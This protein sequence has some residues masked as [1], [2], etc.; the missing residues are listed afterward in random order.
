M[1]LM[2]IHLT[3]ARDPE[4]PEGSEAH[5]YDFVAPLD[6]SGHLDADE[7]RKT[8]DKCRVRRFWN[9]DADE[10]GHLIHTRGRAWVFHYDI[11][12]PLDEDEPGYRFDSHLF[13][14]GEYVSIR[15]QD[16]STR[17]FRVASVRP[18]AVAAKE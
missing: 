4:F 9:G 8:R 5:G 12:G 17:T 11:E 13:K 10:L 18:V 6:Q 3:L 7:W 14:P 15:E 1:A 16:G 2:S